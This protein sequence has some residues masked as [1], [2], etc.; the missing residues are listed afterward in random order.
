MTSLQSRLMRYP[1]A[2]TRAFTS[3]KVPVE[4]LRQRAEAGARL[5]RPVKGVTT[6]SVDAGGVAAEWIIPES[7]EPPDTRGLGVLLYFHGGGFVFCSPRTHRSLV[8]RL[9][10]AAGVR[11]LSVD[12]RLAHEHPYPAALEDC[13]SA[14]HWLL[15]RGYSPTN[16]V[17]AG[18][19]S[20]GNLTLVTLLALRDSGAPLPAGAVCLSPVTDLTGEATS[21]L[22]KAKADPILSHGSGSWL[23][24]YA[25]GAD[26]REALLSPLIADLHGLPPILLQVG[27]E[28]ILLDDSTLF[29]AKAQQAGVDARLEVYPGMW[30]VFQ[31]FAPYLPEARQAVKQI[32]EFIRQ[33]VQ[34]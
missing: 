4:R 20:G 12:Y 16:I 25:G 6:Q 32:G 9:A 22:S 19:S 27:T 11:A 7:V 21:R 33:R 29:A 18:D 5:A 2:L 34:G 8:S 15:S 26:F 24:A 28:E 17:I 1:L 3:G 23:T 30:H 10:L 31:S 14:Y 13:L